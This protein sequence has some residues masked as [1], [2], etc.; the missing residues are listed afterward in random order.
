MLRRFGD[1]SRELR[2]S[3]SSVAMM[4]PQLEWPE[5]HHQPG[6]EAFGRELDA[7][8][9]GGRDDVAGDADHEQV[10]QALVKDDF[11]RHPGV[12]TAQD[13][14][15]RKLLRGQFDAAAGCRWPS[16]TAAGVGDEARIAVAQSAAV[17]LV[18]E[19]CVSSVLVRPGTV[20]STGAGG[21]VRIALPCNFRP[22]ASRTPLMHVNRSASARRRC[23]AA[24][25]VAGRDVGRQRRGRRR[26]PRRPFRPISATRW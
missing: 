25:L 16:I 20:N 14:G 4:A 18:L 5:H 13:D 11:G 7:A 24:V 1:C 22:F 2:P 9:L 21:A 17:L 6:A 10:A 19:S 3:S 26:R 8:D 15:E 23:A 12:R